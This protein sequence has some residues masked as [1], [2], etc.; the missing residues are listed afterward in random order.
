LEKAEKVALVSVFVNTLLLGIKSIF[1]WLS[2]SIAVLADVIHSSSDI[3]AALAVFIGLKI[4]M[5]KSAR[6]PYGLYK[7][8]NFASILLAGGIFFAGY[9]IVKEVFQHETSLQVQNIPAALGG[10]AAVVGITFGLSLY[11]VR[12]GRKLGSPSIQADGYHIRTDMISSVV[13]MMSLGGTLL[14]LNIDRYAA[15]VMALFIAYA[16]SKIF[17]NALRVL[18]D[19]SINFETLDKAKEIILS[20]PVVEEI[21]SLQ[22]RNS[23]SYKF[24]EAEL[25][26]KVRD[27]ERAHFVSQRIDEK[28][29]K[30]IG[31]IDRVLIHY[32]PVQ[33]KTNTLAVALA[34]P[35]GK[36][37]SHFGE[38]PFFGLYILDSKTG[39]TMSQTILSNDFL[40]REQRKG[41][42][43]AEMLVR[44]GIDTVVTKA[45]FQG[46]GSDYVFSDAGVAVM[47]MDVQRAE[48]AIR[49]L[50]EKILISNHDRSD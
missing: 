49:A 25:K 10:M 45:P 7:V 30:H 12:Q 33:K 11:M 18:L 27:L 50:A 37:S 47:Q 42:L 24:I 32:E 28:L 39:K 23:G 4:A 26:L 1:A 38:A 6:F 46:K 19:A 31:N 34:S 14:G 43:V 35:D 22:G 44:A 3:V 8:E 48:D 9:Q 15:A 21:K 36:V 29:R 17:L 20:E 2:G 13:V 5:R 41:I 40:D 16:G